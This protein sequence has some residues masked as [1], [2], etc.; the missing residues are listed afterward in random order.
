MQKLRSESDS[1]CTRLIPHTFAL[2]GGGEWK[3]VYS[4]TKL[5]IVIYFFCSYLGVRVLFLLQC[6]IPASR[7][8]KCSSSRTGF[9]IKFSYAPCWLVD[10][11]AQNPLRRPD[12]LVSSVVVYYW[13]SVSF[14]AVITVTSHFE[15]FWLV[16]SCLHHRQF[17][18]QWITLI[19]SSH[20]WDLGKETQGPFQFTPIFKWWAMTRYQPCSNSSSGLS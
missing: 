14:T 9:F 15:L 19:T 5:E 17:P 1:P 10:D 8:R 3:R 12:F 4:Y 16:M 20:R 2:K 7:G 13:C 6:H 18:K 11:T